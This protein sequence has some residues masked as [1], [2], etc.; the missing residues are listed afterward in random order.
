[1]LKYLRSRVQLATAVLTSAFSSLTCKQAPA[2]LSPMVE[3]GDIVIISLTV[4]RRAKS[5]QK[6]CSQL[7]F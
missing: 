5:R 4:G 3:E 1:M 6:R 7:P 2:L